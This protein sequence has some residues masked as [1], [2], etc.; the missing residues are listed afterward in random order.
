[1]KNIVYSFLL[2]A[3]C[4]ACSADF[5][6]RNPLDKPSNE[7]F[8]KTEKDAL[9][10]AT[11]CY[12]DWW[13]MDEVIYSDCTSDNAFNQ[14]DWEGYA[15]QAAGTAT[16]GTPG[17]HYMDYASMVRYNNFLE[18][19]HR[20]VMD[21]D[22]RKRLIAEV[23]FL[24]AWDYFIKVT[25]YGDVP[26]VTS[27]LGINEANLPRTEKSVVIKFI[28]DELTEI[29]SVLPE[30]YSGSDVGRITRGAALTLKARMLLFEY[31][32]E[33][34]LTTCKEIMGLGYKL[35]PDYKGLFK[36]ANE[37]NEEVIL[38]VQ[39]VESL[40]GTGIL[41]VL[42]PASA[43][44]WCSINPTQALVDAYECKDGKTIE[45]SDVYDPKEPYL[46]RDS[47]LAATVLAPGNLYEGKYY[48]PIDVNDPNGDYYAPY[49]RSKT[50][51]LVRKYVDDLSDYADM[52]DCGMNA[53]V[54]RYAE[55]LLMYAECK[56]ELNSIDESVYTALDDIRT[57]AEMPKVDRAV[58][59]NQDKLREL[60]RRERRVELGMEGLRWFDICRW[61]IGE[62]VMNGKVYGCL[63][64]TVNP[65]TGALSLTDERIFTE[66]R[67][68]DPDKHYLWVIPQSVIDATPAIIQNP[69]Y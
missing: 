20:P 64:G 28:I 65:K 60:L 5:L 62:E 1:M 11:G 42:P 47:R 30:S 68:F 63:L 13:S 18:N 32:Y 31:Q 21:E 9:A 40:Y 55:V 36:I 54:M 4:S 12:S 52:W 34:C 23:R 48:D 15:F 22:L 53:I 45:K 16:P 39:Y 43:G 49:G 57:R 38:D 10:A 25:H 8:W 46:N 44:G 59:N 6:D 61:R 14:F 24:R 56:I 50:G 51:Y 58:Y 29:A 3:L 67:K 27:V 2:V 19:I 41:G 69:N 66:T 33:D 7:A 26:L 37:N 17:H 35:F